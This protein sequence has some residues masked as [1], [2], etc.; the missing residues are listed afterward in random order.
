MTLQHLQTDT[1]SSLFRCKPINGSNLIDLL[2]QSRTTEKTR[3][4]F[5]AD[6]RILVHA[7]DARILLFDS[8]GYFI[9]ANEGQEETEEDGGV[10]DD[11]TP[12]C[13]RTL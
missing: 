7:E 10:L 1:G 3:L 8:E 9:A 13:F 2:G 12:A 6:D 5:A 11:G 4:Y